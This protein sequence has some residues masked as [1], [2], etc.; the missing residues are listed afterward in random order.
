VTIRYGLQEAKEKTIFTT[1]TPVPAGHDVFNYRKL[2]DMLRGYLDGVDINALGGR[3]DL[4]MTTLALNLS[5]YH[6]A[7]SKLH[8]MVSSNMFPGHTIDSIT[9]GVHSDTWTVRVFQKLYDEYFNGYKY[10]E[11]WRS[12]PQL[13]ENIDKVPDEYVLRAHQNAKNKL[14][15]YI[16]QKTG[17]EL[18]TDK[19][20]IGF[21][22]RF[23]TYKRGDLIFSDLERLV[24]ACGDRQV[25]F[26]FSGK[27]HPTDEDGK[28]VI[29]N[30]LNHVDKLKGK[31]DIV[32]LPNYEMDKAQMLVAGVDVWLNLPRTPLEASGTSGIKAA[33][34]AKPSFST[35]DGWWYEVP[36]GAD[37]ERRGGWT[38]GNEPNVNDLSSND[39]DRRKQ[40]E[41]DFD[42]FCYRLK[43]DVRPAYANPAEW[44]RVMKGAIKNASYFNTHRVVKE[45]VEKG[46]GVPLKDAIVK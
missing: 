40:D 16:K 36:K 31:I 3:N 9:N 10:P 21:A 8:G 23:A 14:V 43:N 11:N 17:D 39:T 26:V 19:L 27:A 42:S 15:D 46:Y 13:L 30:V 34:N 32:F 12:N 6:N 22:R 20:T 24:D 38:I 18:S 37:G 7:V 35:A 28:R 2:R 33:H 5:K 29:T 45:Y 25:Q 44:A 41:T 1:H 4:N